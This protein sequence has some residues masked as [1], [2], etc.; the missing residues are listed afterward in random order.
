MLTTCCR[1]ISP[2]TRRQRLSVSSGLPI[3]WSTATDYIHTSRRGRLTAPPQPLRAGELWLKVSIYLE[4]KLVD[5]TSP[6]TLSCCC[7]Y[8]S[9]RLYNNTCRRSSSL[10]SS[11]VSTATPVT[12]PIS[13]PDTMAMCK[14]NSWGGGPHNRHHP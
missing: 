9:G 1:A 10:S 12:S 5:I 13:S 3:S 2:S 4:Y 6:S 14:D 11:N 7:S 8:P